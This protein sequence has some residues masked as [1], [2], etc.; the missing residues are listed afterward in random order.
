MRLSESYQKATP[1]E[2]EKYTNGCGA[3]N[4]KF[5][6]IPDTMWFLSIHAACKAHDW[7]YRKGRIKATKT[8]LSCEGKAKG[9]GMMRFCKNGDCEECVK[10][11]GNDHLDE[12]KNCN[13]LSEKRKADDDFYFN[14]KYIINLKGGFLKYFR[15]IRAFW[16]Y[17]G[18]KK[19]GTTAFWDEGK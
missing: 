3:A 10:T 6:F 16:Y 13:H 17:L 12:K 7:E 15:R 4:A 14:L 8:L 11:Y 1:E 5:D 2:L 18:V 9:F 19:K